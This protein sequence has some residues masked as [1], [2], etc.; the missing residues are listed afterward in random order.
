MGVPIE[1]E[2]YHETPPS[3]DDNSIVHLENE[4]KMYAFYLSYKK[5]T[6]D[7]YY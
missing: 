2:P 6:K 5:V 7:L 4:K 1:T 3:N